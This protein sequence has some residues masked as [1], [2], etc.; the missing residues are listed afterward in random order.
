MRDGSGT[1]IS[2]EPV[3]DALGVV[4]WGVTGVLWMSCARDR[5][6]DTGGEEPRES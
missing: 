1:L 3:G 4:S 2:R 5:V 6:G